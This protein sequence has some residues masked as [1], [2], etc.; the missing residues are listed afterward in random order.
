MGCHEALGRGC[1]KNSFRLCQCQA[2][3]VSDVS[4]WL[5]VGGANKRE[6]AHHNLGLGQ[7]GTKIDF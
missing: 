5:A 4:N 7:N 3:N 6:E 2:S 1:E